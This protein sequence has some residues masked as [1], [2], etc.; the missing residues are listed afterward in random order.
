MKHKLVLLAL[1]VIAAAQTFAHALWIETNARGAQGQPQQVSIFFGEYSENERDS[2][3]HWFS[4]LKDI[5]LFVTAPDGTK[6][7]LPITAETLHFAATFTPTTNGVYTL[8]IAHTVADVYSNMK[9]EYYTA[10]TVGVNSTD[11][12]NLQAATALAVQ[13]AA[14]VTLHQPA[15]INVYNNSQLFTGAKVV[16]VAPDGKEKNLVS[17]AKGAATFTP[18]AAGRYMIEAIRTDKTPGE[19]NGKPYKN[20]THLVTYCISV[21]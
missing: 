13:P 14:A 4:N 20:I 10:A 1:L 12:K 3:A 2:T 6:T 7:A 16:I 8:S 19:H 18:E 5:K 21:D 15:T 9:I 17:N 11:T